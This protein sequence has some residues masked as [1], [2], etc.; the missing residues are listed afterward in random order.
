MNAPARGPGAVVV[1]GY[2]NG[3][4]LVRA[5]A[6]RRIPVAVV[7]TK[8]FDIAHRS[9]WA[10]AHETI[11]TL[12][13]APERL[14]DLLRHRATDW[15]GWL[16]I[17]TNDEALRALAQ[18]RD[19]L[20]TYRLAC[21]NWDVAQYLLDKAEMLEVTRAVGIPAPRCYGSAD[22]SALD[23]PDLRYPVVVK[24]VNGYRFVARFGAKLFVAHTRA[25]LQAALVQLSK[26]ELR[27]QVF[28]LIPGDDSHIYA[29][30]TYIDTRGEPR[31]GLTI[32][33]LRQG[34]P[35]FGNA[36]VAEV[37]PD[38]PL[39]CEMTIEFLRRIGFRGIAA[40]EFKLDPRDATFRF[41][42]VNGRAVVYN[43]LLR[44]A[45]MDV[46]GLLW[47]DHVH[48]APE[49]VQ[50]NN[51]PGVWVNIHADVLYSVLYRQHDPISVR[52]FLAPYRR[53][54]IDAV[55]SVSDPAP[56][57]AQLLW[58]ARRG[59]GALGRAGRRRLLAN[60]TVPFG[61]ER[62]S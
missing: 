47:A 1:G 12:E 33:K 7:V 28:D 10:S 62:D 8:P 42:E 23:N 2:V 34:P 9:R 24:P 48:G 16:V 29:Y 52:Q 37:V 56:S 15:P 21:P 6:A 44:R 19:R 58:S 53:P 61:S 59:A 40:A 26:A 38:Q 43:S 14:V 54:T 18:Y 32:R 36:R 50:P 35:F 51:W 13:D 60:P 30:C 5:L 39:L 41:M 3:L 57:L 46:A 27:A 4:G 31:G 45:G 20:S 55:W 49:R 22:A 17:P 11:E 25:E